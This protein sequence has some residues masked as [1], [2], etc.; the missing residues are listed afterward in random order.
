M[1]GRMPR[2]PGGAVKHL[3]AHRIPSGGLTACRLRADSHAQRSHA[4]G[5]AQKGLLG[6]P[7]HTGGRRAPRTRV[8]ASAI[9]G[10]SSP[11]REGGE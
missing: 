8:Q 5:G 6:C 11:S 9:G 4:Q 2:Q 7:P 10:R 3:T 1:V